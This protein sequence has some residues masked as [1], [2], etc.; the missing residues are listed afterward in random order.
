MGADRLPCASLHNSVVEHWLGVSGWF[1][2][3]THVMRVAD[4]IAFVGPLALLLALAVVFLR[5][6]FYRDFPF[7]F[8][9]VL[10]AIMAMEVRAAIRSLPAAFFAV[11]CAG[12]AVMAFVSVH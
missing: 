11:Y 4:W 1:K 12:G 6:K 2:L 5:R 8:A 7:F 9:Y 10:F 3:A